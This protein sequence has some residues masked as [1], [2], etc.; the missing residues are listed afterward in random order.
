MVN[1]DYQK[2]RPRERGQTDTQTHRDVI[3]PQEFILGDTR[4]AQRLE[5]GPT[6]E[7]EGRKGKGS[8]GRE[9][10]ASF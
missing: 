1:K 7:A 8:L 2:L 3:R 4:G 6:F 9:Q 10:Q 5:L